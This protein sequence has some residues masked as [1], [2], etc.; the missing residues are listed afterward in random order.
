M[1][2]RKVNNLTGWVVFFLAFITY[3]LTREATGF[4]NA[5]LGPRRGD[6]RRGMRNR[7]SFTGAGVIGVGVGEPSSP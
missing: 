4:A 5:R 6:R 1:N 3:F 7:D 2:F